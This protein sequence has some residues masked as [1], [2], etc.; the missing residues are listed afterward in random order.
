MKKAKSECLDVV[1]EVPQE[2]DAA[3]LEHYEIWCSIIAGNRFILNDIIVPV[4]RLAETDRTMR[5][6]KRELMY[7][8]KQSEYHF[9]K[10]NYDTCKYFNDRFDLVTAKMKDILGDDIYYRTNQ[11]Y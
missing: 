3:L 6:L 10:G 7:C 1:I 9:K 11:L 5:K 4:D 2:L 8:I